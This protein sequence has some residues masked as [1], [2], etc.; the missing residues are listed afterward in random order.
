MISPRGMCAVRPNPTRD[1][2]GHAGNEC[3]TCPFEH[4]VAPEAPKLRGM[5]GDLKPVVTNQEE[6]VRAT[7]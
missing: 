2:A 3:V 7:W 1:Q 4:Y 6:I 5:Q